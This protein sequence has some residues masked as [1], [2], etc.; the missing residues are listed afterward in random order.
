MSALATRCVCSPPSSVSPLIP[1][2]L[3][4]GC[5]I[6]SSSCDGV[7]GQAPGTNSGKFV[8]AGGGAPPNDW[9]KGIVADPKF[10][11]SALG[12]TGFP[13]PKFLKYP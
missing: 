10:M 6:G 13:R 11:N 2:F 3:A 12:R 8:Y 4:T 1:P 9:D 5:D 7:T